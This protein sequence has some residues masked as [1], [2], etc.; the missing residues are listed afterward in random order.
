MTTF[1]AG[2]RVW[3]RVRQ[4]SEGEG[5]RDMSHSVTVPYSTLIG[6]GVDHPSA[7]RVS[8]FNTASA[9]SNTMPP[10]RKEMWNRGVPAH[11]ST[12]HH[13]DRPTVILYCETVVRYKCE[14]SDRL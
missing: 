10:K 4:Y 9:R 6:L 11:Y 5:R 8:L 1:L 14:R 2:S 3:V 13:A 12:L 7:P